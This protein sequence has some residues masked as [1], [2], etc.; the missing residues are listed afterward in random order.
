[1]NKLISMLKCV[2]CFVLLFSAIAG[3]TGIW[4]GY[5]LGTSNVCEQIDHY[6]KS[7]AVDVLACSKLK[8][9]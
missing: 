6:Y 5:K 3:V 2:I 9:N 4:I 8:N 7:D 1:M